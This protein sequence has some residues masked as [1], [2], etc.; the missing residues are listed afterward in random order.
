MTEVDIREHT[1]K[2]KT[3]KLVK[4]RGYRRRVGRKGI[5]SPKRDKAASAG[6]E[7]EERLKSQEPTKSPEEIKAER[8]RLRQ[9]QQDYERSERERKYLGMSRERYSRYKFQQVME[10]K[11][12]DAYEAAHSD[13]NKTVQQEMKQ[14]K[15]TSG[16]RRSFFDKVE[17]VLAK[18]VDKYGGGM[19]YK[20][21]N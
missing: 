7:F 13:V 18:F 3:G 16:K 20:R 14:R 11:K 19:K 17:D 9:W 4:V 15:S 21:R 2:S 5:H 8:E 1:R 10:G 6:K 12:Y